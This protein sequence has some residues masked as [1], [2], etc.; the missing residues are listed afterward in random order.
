MQFVQRGL[1]FASTAP[2]EVQHQEDCVD[3]IGWTFDSFNKVIRFKK[4]K[5]VISCS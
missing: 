3:L 1:L 2:E 5:D 4:A